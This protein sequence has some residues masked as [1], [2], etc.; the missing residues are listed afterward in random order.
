MT[1]DALTVSGRGAFATGCAVP[2][3]LLVSAIRDDHT[4]RLVVVTPGVG[5]GVSHPPDWDNLGQRSTASGSIAFDNVRLARGDVLGT[6][7][8]GEEESDPRRLRLSLVSLAF[9]ATLTQVLIGIA[10]GA[11]DEA[12]RYTRRHSRPWPAS[13][14]ERAVDDP[15]VLAG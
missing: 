6:F 1:G 5:G 15:H 4:A 14:L 2:D 13:G 11:L 7:P 8:A 12:A 3:R 9:Q 10:D